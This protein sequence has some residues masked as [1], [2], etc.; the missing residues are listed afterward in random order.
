MPNLH[1]LRKNVM[2][3]NARL[4]NPVNAYLKQAGSLNY[5]RCNPDQ[6]P[7]KSDTKALNM[8]ANWRTRF[9]K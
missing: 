9:I 7:D 1:E 2:A 5:I 8:F 4:Q 3:K 6:K